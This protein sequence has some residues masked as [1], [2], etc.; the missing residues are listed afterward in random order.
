[1]YLC[2]IL[3][4]NTHILTFIIVLI[5]IA[6]NLVL[7][8][9]GISKFIRVPKAYKSMIGVYRITNMIEEVTKIMLSTFLLLA[10]L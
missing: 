1:M 9:S 2:L 6:A 3:Y 4:V 10:V 5:S 8:L 7:N